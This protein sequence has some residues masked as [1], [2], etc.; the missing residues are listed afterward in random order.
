MVYPELVRR[1]L[2]M[3]IQKNNPTAPGVKAIPSTPIVRSETKGSGTAAP[4]TRFGASAISSP[5]YQQ[6]AERAYQ[7]Y[8]K[9]GF[10]PGNAVTDWLEAERQ[11]KAGL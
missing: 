6:I 3:A 11:L 4:A 7:I 10:G 9:R 1:S 2:I 5:T 8:L